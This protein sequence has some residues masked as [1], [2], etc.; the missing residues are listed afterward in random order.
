MLKSQFFKL[1][2]REI[3]NK[4]LQIEKDIA[5]NWKK[6]AHISLT[7]GIGGVPIF[8]YMLYKL[9]KKEVYLSKIYEVVEEI[10]DMLDSE[11]FK[12][13]FSSGLTGLGCVFNFL[14]KNNVL[15]EEN[16]N[17]SLEI[18]DE[19]IA[20]FTISNLSSIDDV[21]FLHGAL[22]GAYYLNERLKDNPLIKERTIIIFEKLAS[23]IL[24]DIKKTYE[25]S[26]LLK[27]DDETHR[28]NCGLA[29]GHISYMIIFSKFIENF[30]N[31]QLIISAIRES[32]KCVLSFE[33]NNKSNLSLFP[34][35]AINKHTA[36]YNIHLGWCYGDQTIS[37]G[38]QKAAK[39]LNDN[40]LFEKAKEIAIQ[41]LKRDTFVKALKSH[42]SDA[43]MCHGT[44]SLAYLHKKWHQITK[45]KRFDELYQ[46]FIK[47]TL[48]K[49]DSDKGI[50]GYKKYIGNNNFQDAIGFLDGAVGIGVVLIDYLLENETIAWDSFFLLD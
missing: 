15:K 20:D 9:E 13:T 19:T 10:F 14:R 17:E 26:T 4:V 32:A 34:G 1:M 25:V 27:Y 38:L 22:G 3:Y 12:L 11:D 30:P 43:S 5:L 49:G 36:E 31:N 23:I 16:I 45:D 35:I 8:Y 28:T 2:R 48:T 40:N 33:S 50:G 47:E 42:L 41:T 37:F 21:D 6:D 44:S 18:I 7:T 29:H 39:T 24:D 46:K